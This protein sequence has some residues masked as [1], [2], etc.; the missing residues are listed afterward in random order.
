LRTKHCPEDNFF[1]KGNV[2]IDSAGDAYLNTLMQNIELQLRVGE[3]VVI[4]EI[5][6]EDTS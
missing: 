4:R 3:F 2:I 1:A 5:S 6:S